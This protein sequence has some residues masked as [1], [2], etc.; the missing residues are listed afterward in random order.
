MQKGPIWVQCCSCK[1]IRKGG[2]WTHSTGVTPKHVRF[3]HGYCPDCLNRAIE[4]VQTWMPNDTTLVS[5]KRHT[6]ESLT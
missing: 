6:V 2:T 4:E 1:R 5:R 3:S